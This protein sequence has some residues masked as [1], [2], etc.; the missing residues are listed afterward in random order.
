MERPE[1]VEQVSGKRAIEI[2]SGTGLAGLALAHLG[3]HVTL[4]DTPSVLDIIHIN[5]KAN[6]GKGMATRADVAPCV[7]GEDCGALKPPY[8]ILLASDVLYHEDSHGPLLATLRDLSDTNTRIIFAY[9]RRRKINDRFF[10]KATKYFDWKLIPATD[11]N[12]GTEDAVTIYLMQKR[13]TPLAK[14]KKT[15]AYIASHMIPIFRP[16]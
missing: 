9:E 11:I 16:I 5:I 12:P 7:W 4:T 2:G 13:D 3:A 14:N 1:I 8:E 10:K 6:E 15:K